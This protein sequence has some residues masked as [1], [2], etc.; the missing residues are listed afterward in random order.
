MIDQLTSMGPKILLVWVFASLFAAILL[1]M[2]CTTLR[3]P[4]ALRPFVVAILVAVACW[5]LDAPMLLIAV[6]AFFTFIVAR[7]VGA[8][9]LRQGVTIFGPDWHTVD[10]SAVK[11]GPVERLRG[12]AAAIRK[13]LPGDHRPIVQARVIAAPDSDPAR[14]GILRRKAVNSH[15]L[16]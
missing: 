14:R 11:G 7:I 3:V 2:A 8:I 10:Y 16:L 5:Y 1:A 6:I 9:V 15:A 13:A 12:E 4:A